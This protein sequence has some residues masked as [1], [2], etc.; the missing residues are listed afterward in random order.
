VK[1]SCDGIADFTAYV[2]VTSP[3]SSPIGTV[4]FSGG[5]TGVGLYEHYVFGANALN[6]VLQAGYTAVQTSF[7]GPFTTSTP[8]GWVTGPGGVRR[9]AC[10]YATVMRWVYD[11]VHRANAAQPLC[12]TGNS[13]GSQMIGESL[14]HYGV[15]RIVSMVEASS[16]PPYSRL[17][18]GCVCN[19]PPKLGPCGEGL[20][21]QCVAADDA[22]EFI[23]PA[24]SSPICS[25][26]QT[27]HDTTNAPEFISDSIPSPDA[28][29]GYPHTYVHFAF[30]DLD[31]SSAVTLGE[32]WESVITTPN[33]FVCVP[34][35]GHSIADSLTGAQQVATDIINHCHL[36]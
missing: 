32:D 25:S 24:Y 14:A 16:G 28:T 35:A 8:N 30:G 26:A 12:A 29:L 31:R 17:D 19:A 20:V 4:I 6:S 27:T 7:G 33:A 34:N 1:L 9:L 18:Y 2:K 22:K 15:D 13:A 23:D 5:G 3:S 21:S 10:R 11:K 36:N